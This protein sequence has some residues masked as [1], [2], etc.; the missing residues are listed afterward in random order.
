MVTAT[1]H[2]RQCGERKKVSIRLLGRQTAVLSRIIAALKQV[3]IEG[4]EELGGAGPGIVLF[5]C[6]TDEVSDVISEL[7]RDGFERVLA[8]A[9]QR[10]P[11]G[12]DAAWRFL[13]SGAADVVT[14]DGDT[15]AEA[16]ITARIDRWFAVDGLLYAS[17]VQDL[18]A[19]SSRTWLKVLRQV[20]EVAR[21]TDASVL[22]TGPSGSGKELIARLIHDLDPRSN[23]GDLVVLDSATVVPQLSGSEFFGHERGAFTGA[24]QARDGSFARAEGGTLFLDE[25][26]ELPLPL[27]AELLRVVQ[28]RTYKRVGSNTWR[29][30]NFRLVCATNRD[31]EHE[32]Q[33]GTFREDFYHRLASFRCQ[34]PALKERRADILP[35][36]KHF[37]KQHFAPDEPP[38]LDAPIRDFL[39]TRRFPGNIRELKQLVIQIAQ[40]HLDAGP[41]TIGC[42]P[43][44]EIASAAALSNAWPDEHFETSIRDALSRGKGLDAIRNAATE[45]AYSIV[46]TDEDGDTAQASRRLKI[47]QRAVQQHLRHKKPH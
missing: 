30:A 9:V 17:Q 13:Q 36:V 22:I 42:L 32:Q 28:E 10:N 11:L 40:R 15:K 41:I 6:V 35:L 1:S 2:A 5:D 3:D 26:G 25:V 39:L 23:K 31:L 29:K 21:F 33:R 47:S 4:S 38:E 7:S 20:V 24:D 45:K 46:L 44:S 16:L 12:C 8:V 27:Q 19:G 14:W 18:L 43:E 37:L 34:L